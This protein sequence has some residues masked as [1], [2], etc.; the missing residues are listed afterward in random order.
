MVRLFIARKV[1]SADFLAVFFNCQSRSFPEVGELR[2][3]SWGVAPGHPEPIVCYQN[4]PVATVPRSNTAGRNPN[5]LR[6]FPGALDGQTFQGYGKRT[7]IL[8]SLCVTQERLSIPLN[9]VS[10]HL[11]DALGTQAYV[12]HHWDSNID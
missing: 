2:N 11:M 10:T 9:S 12:C 5:L 8:S 7:S 6:D 4:L 1:S 3:K